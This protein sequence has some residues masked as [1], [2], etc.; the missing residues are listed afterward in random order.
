MGSW[1]GQRASK[2]A[3]SIVPPLFRADSGMN[4]IKQGENVK[5]QPCG[6]VALQIHHKKVMQMMIMALKI[7]QPPSEKSRCYV[8][9][10]MV[11]KHK[12]LVLNRK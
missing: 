6:S 9:P 12:Q 11:C 5:G 4:L 1:L 10:V 8:V 7:L 3:C 2:G